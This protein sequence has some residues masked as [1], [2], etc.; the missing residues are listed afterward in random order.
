MT[1]TKTEIFYKLILDM[2]Y[3][4]LCHILLITKTYTSTRWEGY[5]VV[6]IPGG[7]VARTILEADYNILSALSY[8]SLYNLA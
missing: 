6:C 8:S 4:Q 1:K 7:G 2:T 5:T 3:H